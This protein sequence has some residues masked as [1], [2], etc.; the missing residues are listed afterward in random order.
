MKSFLKF[1]CSPLSMLTAFLLG[2]I[3][4]F[5]ISPIKKGIYFGNRDITH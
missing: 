2:I 3:I 5:L 1:E 4:G